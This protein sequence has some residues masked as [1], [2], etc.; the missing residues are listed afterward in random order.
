MYGIDIVPLGLPTDHVSNPHTTTGRITVSC[1]VN[2]VRL[3][4]A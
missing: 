4:S 2:N 1:I 3:S